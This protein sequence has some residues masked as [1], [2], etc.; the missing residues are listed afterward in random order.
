M[1]QVKKKPPKVTWNE[2]AFEVPEE[3][4]K[5]PRYKAYGKLLKR[6]PQSKIIEIM[7]SNGLSEAEIAAFF[8]TDSNK[9]IISS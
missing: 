3:M 7:T 8:G 5:Q 1:L 6:F 4:R 9:A 2:S